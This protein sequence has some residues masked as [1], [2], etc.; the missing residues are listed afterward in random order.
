MSADRCSGRWNPFRKLPLVPAHC[1]ACWRRNQ[2][3]LAG[4]FRQS[5]VVSHRWQRRRNLGGQVCC[6]E[7]GVV[8]L[9]RT[10]SEG[11]AVVSSSGRRLCLGGLAATLGLGNQGSQGSPVGIHLTLAHL[12]IQT[13]VGCFPDCSAGRCLRAKA[14][15]FR[16]AS[17]AGRCRRELEVE[18]TVG[19]AGHCLLGRLMGRWKESR[20]K[21]KGWWI[22]GRQR[23]GRKRR[24]WVMAE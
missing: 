2:L 19:S 22:R 16:S 14:G 12:E 24:G 21:W 9:R 23:R 1:W 8:G 5:W 13:A 18:Q 7:P 4:S 10:C 3:S 20:W 15:M 17:S 11:G 6:S